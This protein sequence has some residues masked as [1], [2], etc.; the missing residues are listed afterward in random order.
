MTYA[1]DE[2]DL[3]TRDD[4]RLRRAVERLLARLPHGARTVTAMRRESTPV[5]S[6]Y[7]A[8]V[9]S[10]EL[11]DGDRLSLFV[12]HLD[13]GGS[14]HPDKRCR[15]REIRI[16]EEL[17]GECALPVVQCYG[18]MRDDLTSR[19]ELFLEYI[20][21]WDLRY[22][23]LELWYA[24]A[25]RLG[26]LHAYFAEHA[27]RL[28]RCDWLLRLDARYLRGWAE[29]AVAVAG[30]YDAA[31][32]EAL[33]EVARDIGRVVETLERQPPTLVHNDLAPKNVLV[34]RAAAPPR[35]AFVDWEMAGIGCGAL[36]LVDLKYGLDAAADERMRA[37]YCEA[38]A[39][40]KLLPREPEG[41]ARLLAAAELHRTIYRLAHAAAWSLPA[42][43]V[44]RWVGEATQLMARA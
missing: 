19:R 31:A 12:K 37:A 42:D 21:D 36:D 39:G 24:A 4:G 41:L 11:D 30:A 34:H 15:D 32:G 5:V 38:L 44:R 27:E 29:R 43:T 28:F 1:T 35:V 20:P 33:R 18:W 26:D 6:L 17:L 2:T 23:E 7:P 14:V 8:E 16:Y 40:T 25:R 9:L 22:Q 13:G 10:L 3:A